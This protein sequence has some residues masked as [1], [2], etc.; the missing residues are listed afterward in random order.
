VRSRYSGLAIF[1][2]DSLTVFSSRIFTPPTRPTGKS[3]FTVFGALVARAFLQTK[4]QKF[5]ID[6]YPDDLKSEKYTGDHIA[7]IALKGVR[8]AIRSRPISSA[9]DHRAIH[10]G[11]RFWRNRIKSS[12]QLIPQKSFMWFVTM[13]QNNKNHFR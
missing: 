13:P 3:K 8:C 12:L 4:G 6:C 1:S 2:I 10:A 11:L 9:F 5:T 7:Q